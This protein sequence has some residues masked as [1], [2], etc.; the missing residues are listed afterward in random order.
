MF[1][2]KLYRR[3]PGFNESTTLYRVSR[4]GLAIA[5][6]GS[7]SDGATW[8]SWPWM[9]CGKGKFGLSGAGGDDK[10]GEECDEAGVVSHDETSTKSGVTD[11]MME[12]LESLI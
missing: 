7:I 6:F 10:V 3:M 9:A 1:Q 2:K 8:S 5:E 11:R 4:V 12:D